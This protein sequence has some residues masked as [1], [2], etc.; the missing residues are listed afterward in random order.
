V[1]RLSRLASFL[2]A[3]SL[4]VAPTAQAGVQARPLDMAAL[5]TPASSILRWEPEFMAASHNYTRAQAIAQATE[6]DVIIATKG[7]FA[8]YLAAMKAANPSLTLLFYVNGGYS[9]NDNG[10]MFPSDTYERDKSGRKIKSIQFGSLLMNVTKSAWRSHVRDKCMQGIA[11]SGY[12]GCFL[13]S[14][15]PAALAPAYVTGLPI[16]PNTGQVWTRKA[17]LSAT[18]GLAHVVKLALGSKPLVVNGVQQ[19]PSYFDSTG[20]TGVLADGV[21]GGMVELFVR[22]PFA[23]IT[24]HRSLTKWHQDVG[25]LVDAG[26]K[27][28]TLLCVT[29]AWVKATATQM[30]Q[31]HLFALGT[32]LLGTNGTDFFSFLDSYVTAKADSVWTV[33]LGAPSGHYLFSQSVYQRVFARGRVLVNPTSA[34]HTVALPRSYRDASGA[35]VTSVRVRTYSAVILTLP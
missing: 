34:G 8:G 16:N 13:D 2:L 26:S 29:K 31:A 25:M 14:L 17:W 20:S 1:L 12:D 15:G 9:V 33:Q 32:F 28:R 27:G 6:F 19:G 30:A 3:M 22:P 24:T 7:P 21:R 35:L 11:A 18:S 10:T 5:A 4:L 23:S